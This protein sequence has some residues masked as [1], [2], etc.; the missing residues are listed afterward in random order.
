VCYSFIGID[1]SRALHD[2]LERMVEQELVASNGD[3]CFS[4]GDV[5]PNGKKLWMALLGPE[6][7]GIIMQLIHHGF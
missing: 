4:Y 2:D 1:A 7:S 3:L 6:S 5:L